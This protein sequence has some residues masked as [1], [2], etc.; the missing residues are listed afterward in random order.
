[1]YV[2]N[3]ASQARSM[4]AWVCVPCVFITGTSICNFQNVR[5][6]QHAMIDEGTVTGQHMAGR[7]GLA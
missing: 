3:L 2:F 7:N 5:S 6:Q 4:S 1:M